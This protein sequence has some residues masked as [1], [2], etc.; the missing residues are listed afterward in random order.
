[1]LPRARELVAERLGAK[2]AGI[3]SCEEI[4]FIA[5]QC[6][7]TP[8]YH[9]VAENTHVELLRDDGRPASPGEI[10]QVVVTGLYNYAMPFIRYAI[11]DVA[12]AAEGPCACGR[13]L[14]VLAQILGRTRNAFVF[15][16]GKRVWLR[17]N[18][19]QAIGEFVP[20]REFQMVQTDRRQIEF[21]YIPDGSGRAP[22][23]AGLDALVRT[24]IHPSAA[25]KLIPMQAITRGPGGKLEPF[26]TLV[27]D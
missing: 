3:Y 12:I 5:T 9:I 26:I 10:G 8:G 13:G 19:A 25:I 14:P 22:D 7:D 11:G 21:R 15:E 24:R 17:I 18:D 4:G 6:P 23:L 2:L 27:A 1:V 16:D 20:F